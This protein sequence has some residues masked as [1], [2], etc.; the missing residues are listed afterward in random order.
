MDDGPEIYRTTQLNLG[1]GFNLPGDRFTNLKNRDFECPGAGGCY[2]T[3][4]DWELADLFDVGR[5]ILCYRTFADLCEMLLHY[6]RRPG[7]CLEIARAGFERA[8]R[9]HTWAH[10]FAE[11]FRQAGLAVRSP[12]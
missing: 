7:A 4:F 3:T 9:E 5:E 10:R 1:I 11:V 8:R 12:S 6:G 2:L